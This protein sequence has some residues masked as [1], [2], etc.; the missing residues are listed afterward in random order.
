[1]DTSYLDR[2]EKRIV[3]FG[4]Y[5]L[6]KEREERT[7]EIN[8][9]KVTDADLANWREKQGIIDNHNAVDLATKKKLT[10][11]E[12]IEQVLEPLLHVHKAKFR[13]YIEVALELKEDQMSL[14]KKQQSGQSEQLKAEVFTLANKL[15]LAGEGDAAGAMHRIHNR[16]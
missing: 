1:M 11:P 2:E 9:D 4:N 10:D 15:A 5:V 7:S 12:I 3:S 8:Q 16:L 14:T 6:S 13:R